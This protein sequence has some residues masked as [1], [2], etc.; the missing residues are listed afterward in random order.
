L[1]WHSASVYAYEWLSD[2]SVVSPGSA[3]ACWVVTA[4]THNGTIM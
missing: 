3:T 2:Y 4:V 1:S